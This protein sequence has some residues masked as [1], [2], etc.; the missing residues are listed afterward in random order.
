VKNIKT[1]SYGFDS[2]DTFKQLKKVLKIK[3][4]I[5]S[6]PKVSKNLDLIDLILKV[7]IKPKFTPDAQKLFLKFYKKNFNTFN[8]MITSRGINFTNLHEIRNHFAIYFYYFYE[9]I[10]K[11]KINLII[12]SNLPHQGPDFIVYELAKILKIKTILC[13]QTIFKNKFF[14]INNLNE[15]G[16]F[17][18]FN[19][20]KLEKEEIDSN[21]YTNYFKSKLNDEKKKQDNIVNLKKNINLRQIIRNIAI[22]SK[23]IK[24]VNFEKRYLDNLRKIKINKKKLNEILNLNKKIIFVALNFQP[25]LT[26]SVLGLDYEDQI[27]MLEKIYKTFNKSHTIIVKDHPLQTSF[28]R[29]DYFFKRL[30][31]L[32]NIYIVDNS[33]DSDYLI[34]KSDIISTVS[35]TIGWEALLRNKKCL[36]FGMGWYHRLHGCLKINDNTKD[37]HLRKFVN[38]KFQKKKFESN[39]R[40]LISNTFDGVIDGYYEPFVDKFN[41]LENAK[42][43]GFQFSNYLKKNYV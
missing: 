19:K 38:S 4:S 32:K 6:I 42:K 25:E 34:N 40:N 3:F 27:L 14:V 18:K 15:F 8:I 7:N 9:I 22:K 31:Y 29:G 43:I 39:F 28:Q 16:N 41:S 36:I 17:K 24:R 33:I 23:I 10:I 35:G 12:F 26:T 30:N 20:L 11:K 5:H 1:L 37:S 2:R 13:Y 21:Q